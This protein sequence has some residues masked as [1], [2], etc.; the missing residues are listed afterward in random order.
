MHFQHSPLPQSPDNRKRKAPL[1]PSPSPQKRRAFSAPTTPIKNPDPRSTSHPQ[2]HPKT[3]ATRTILED[4]SNQ[5]R[6]NLEQKLY[7][8]NSKILASGNFGTS[9]VVGEKGRQYAIKKSMTNTVIKI[10]EDVAAALIDLPTFMR[11]YQDISPR[12]MLFM[13]YLGSSDLCKIVSSSSS[14]IE[15]IPHKLGNLHNSFINI[16]RDFSELNSRGFYYTDMKLENLVPY[17]GNLAILKVADIDG[18]IRRKYTSPSTS[19]ESIIFTP[20]YAHPFIVLNAPSI[21]EIDNIDLQGKLD[22]YALSLTE[23]VATI[24]LIEKYVN[25]LENT[26]AISNIKLKCNYIINGI[27]STPT[28][29]TDYKLSF[30]SEDVDNLYELIEFDS[31]F[32]NETKSF[33]VNFLQHILKYVPDHIIQTS[34]YF[35]IRSSHNKENEVPAVTSSSSSSSSSEEEILRNQQKKGTRSPLGLLHSSKI[36]KKH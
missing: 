28:K 21:S 29:S 35:S 6:L 16:T 24:F 14:V 10:P 11:A 18:S 3:K 7:L 27:I 17:N 30:L 2:L 4:I 34:E 19:S 12:S 32:P 26:P 20:Q 5:E 13:Q 22:L 36:T 9:Y 8:K 33:F 23:L 1:V 31:N 25:N 15:D